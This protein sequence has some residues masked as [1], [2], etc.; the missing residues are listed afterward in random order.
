[1]SCV[2]PDWSE[3]TLT[4]VINAMPKDI[5]H[6]N[7]TG[8]RNSMRFDNDGGKE[9]DVDD[10]D[11]GGESTKSSTLIN[12]ANKKVR[13]PFDFTKSSNPSQPDVSVG[14]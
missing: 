8:F 11:F 10:D 13:R 9:V 6:L 7:L 3:D 4:A 12:K 14:P 5:L 2:K 1:V